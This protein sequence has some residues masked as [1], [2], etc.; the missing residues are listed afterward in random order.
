MTKWDIWCEYSYNLVE[1]T[2]SWRNRAA[3]YNTNVPQEREILFHSEKNNWDIT[4]RLVKH[5]WQHVLCQKKL[6]FI[7]LHWEQILSTYISQIQTACFQSSNQTLPTQCAVSILMGKARGTPRLQVQI[8][9]S[10]TFG[11]S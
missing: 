11:L 2:W 5:Q 8:T 9:G 3:V 7:K 6:S 4:V 10:T 1:K